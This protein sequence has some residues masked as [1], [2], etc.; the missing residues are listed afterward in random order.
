[1]FIL[2]PLDEKGVPKTAKERCEVIKTVFEEAKKYGFDERDIVVDGLV[3]TV[4]SDQNAPKETLK[5]IRWATENMGCNTVIGLSNVS[6]GL[7]ERVWVNSAFLSMAQ[8]SGLTIAILNPSEETLMN[9]KRAG[10]VLAGKDKNSSSYIEH[11]SGVSKAD[12]SGLKAINGKATERAR[13]PEEKIYDA[14]VNGDS[15]HIVEHIKEALDKGTSASIIVDRF[16]IPAITLT[17]D[18]YEK[19]KYYLPQLIQSA[20]AMKQ[21]FSYVEPL[22]FKLADENTRIVKIVLATVK[23]DI[24]D[25]G[26]NIVGLMLKNYGFKVIDMGKD[27]PAELIVQKAQEEKADIIALSALMTTTMNQMSKVVEICKAQG[28]SSKIIVGGAVVSEKFAKEIGAD[29]Y[30]ADAYGAVKLVQKLME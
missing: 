8:G 18:L 13:E 6:F 23:G 17:G 25:I 16:M 9:T 12:E 28:V 7:P 29:G 1:M 15:E 10:D 21:G 14:I 20:Q 5:V 3:M 24:H 2:L 30:A 26:K 19:K 11:F 22:L 4:S 27:V